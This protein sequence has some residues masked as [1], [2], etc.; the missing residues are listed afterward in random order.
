L[1]VG[2]AG[3]LFAWRGDIDIRHRWRDLW[4]SGRRSR[5][6]ARLG[7]WAGRRRL[8][9]RIGGHDGFPLFHQRRCRTL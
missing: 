1:W 2:G 5:G 7:G 3:R 6:L 9:R 4:R 8:G